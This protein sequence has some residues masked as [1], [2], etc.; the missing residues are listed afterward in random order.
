M[1]IKI[2]HDSEASRLYA[3]IEGERC[4][5]DYQRSGATITI[6]HTGVPAKLGGRGIA[7]ALVGAAFELARAEGWKVIPACS[8]AEV[9]A[10]RHPEYADL[11]V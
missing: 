5:L 10:G 9:F 7:A 4:L 8:Y 1:D 11:L 6:T 2:I 3:D